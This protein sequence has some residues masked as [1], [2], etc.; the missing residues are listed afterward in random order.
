MT[1]DK[2]CVICYENILEKKKLLK[3]CECTDSLSCET[4]Y[5][6]LNE[7]KIKKCPVCKK[8][9][10]YNINKYV[11]SNLCIYLNKNK[12]L[13]FNV[14]INLIVVNLVI[15]YTFYKNTNYPQIETKF[16]I[17]KNILLKD[18]IYHSDYFFYHKNTYFILINIFNLLIYPISTLFINLVLHNHY[19]N[20]IYILNNNTIVFYF[21]IFIQFANIFLIL[22]SKKNFIFLQLYLVSVSLIYTVVTIVF[23]YIFLVCLLFNNYNYIKNNYMKFKYRIKI[24]SIEEYK[25]PSLEDNY[26]CVTVI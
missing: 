4:C 6:L 15:Y 26:L 11:C 10:K 19:N 18:Y 2:K 25:E 17:N 24:N 22:I 5:E 13:F 21:N 9:L 7:K 20:F 23:V 3:I 1:E 14:F 16:N 8:T 12:L